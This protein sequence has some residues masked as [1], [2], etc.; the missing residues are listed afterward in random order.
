MAPAILHHRRG[1]RRLRR[2]RSAALRVHRSPDWLKWRTFGS[3]SANVSAAPNVAAVHLSRMTPLPNLSRRRLP[4]IARS[5]PCGC[6]AVLC[7]PPLRLN[8]SYLAAGAVPVA[9]RRERANLSGTGGAGHRAVCP[10]RPDG[11]VRAARRSEAER[12][13]RQAV[14]RSRT[15]AVAAEVWSR[16]SMPTLASTTSLHQGPGPRRISPASSSAHRSH[17]MS[18]RSRSLAPVQRSPR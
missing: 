10:R 1:G 17:S 6:R 7:R 12:A 15:S 4:A 3:C 2:Q 5:V 18:P 16:S 8:P 9:A 14:L 13:F 11:R